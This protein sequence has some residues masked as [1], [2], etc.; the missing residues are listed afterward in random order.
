MPH[1]SRSPWRAG[2]VQSDIMTAP[3]SSR[4]QTPTEAVRQLVH[5]YRDRCLWY[6][7]PDY[8]PSTSE[9]Q[10]HVLNAIQRYGDREAFRR[11]AALKRRLSPSS[12]APPADC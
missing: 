11:A 6:L 8:Y 2:E 1:T 10:L 12:V 5:E 4:Q 9:E 3:S 7:R